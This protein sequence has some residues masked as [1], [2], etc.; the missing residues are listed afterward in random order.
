MNSIK[1]IYAN[2][3]IIGSRDD[4]DSLIDIIQSND[5]TLKIIDNYDRTLL[6]SFNNDSSISNF[7]T[8][9]AKSIDMWL[10]NI[11]I[12]CPIKYT[13]NLLPLNTNQFILRI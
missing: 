3:M 12:T 5:P 1:E 11:S 10:N 13:Y 6:I 7:E 9:F 2:K 4:F 8:T